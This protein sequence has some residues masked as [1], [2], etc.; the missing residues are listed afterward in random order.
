MIDRRTALRAL[1][2]LAFG[3]RP[4]LAS[5]GREAASNRHYRRDRCVLRRVSASLARGRVDQRAEHR[6]R[7]PYDSRTTRADSK[8]GRRSRGAKARRHRRLGALMIAAFKRATSTIPIVAID[9]ESDPVASGFIARLSAPRGE[10]H[11][12]CSWIFRSSP[13]S[14]S[15]S[16]RRRCR[17]SRA[18]P[19]LWDTGHW[20]APA[21]GDQGR[22]AAGRALTRS[23]RFLAPLRTSRAAFDRAVRAPRSSRCHPH[24]SGDIGQP[25]TYRRADAQAPFAGD[26]SLHV[27]SGGW[28]SDGLRAKPP[29]TSTAGQPATSTGYSKARTSAIYQWSACK[30]IRG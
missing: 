16:S 2:T 26:Q 8:A 29:R 27:A 13:A 24:I 9:F 11:R 23:D 17:A 4:A 30:Q 25:E 18:S 15:S 14:S 28:H 6:G 19:S 20:R 3:V 1:G 12:V 5:A 7:A 22:R 10:Y 21:P